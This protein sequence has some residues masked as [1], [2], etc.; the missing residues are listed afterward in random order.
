[1]KRMN[2]QELLKRYAAGERDFTE[3]FVDGADELAGA[4]L[5]EIDLSGAELDE[6]LFDFTVLKGAKLVGTGFGQSGLNCA[7][8][9]EADLSR[10]RLSHATLDGSN[11]T[12]A[13]LI[14]VDLSSTSMLSV[15]LT[16]ANLT[17]A[18]FS[19]E[20]EI[21]LA[22]TDGIIYQNTIMPDGS[23]RTDDSNN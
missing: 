9:Q 18:M 22:M 6:M 2:A 10:A 1:M 23:I 15:N 4:D 21:F 8:L 11:L 13:K 20:E 7:D 19:E 3:V 5:S 14:G 16:E 17:G 12:R